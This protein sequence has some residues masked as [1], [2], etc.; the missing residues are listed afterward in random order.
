MLQGSVVQKLIAVL[1]N[2]KE[3]EDYFPILMLKVGLCTLLYPERKR[4]R[5]MTSPYC[6]YV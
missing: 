5:L 1:I 2:C 6:L 3:Q 4:S